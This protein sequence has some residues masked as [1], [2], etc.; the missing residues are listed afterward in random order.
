MMDH[1]NELLA[2]LPEDAD[3]SQEGENGN[4]EG[5]VDSEASSG[6]ED[7]DTQWFHHDVGSHMNSNKQAWLIGREI[8]ILLSNATD[9]QWESEKRHCTLLAWFVR[10]SLLQKTVFPPKCTACSCHVG[11]QPSGHLVEFRVVCFVLL[12][13]SQNWLPHLNRKQGISL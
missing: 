11:R 1:V 10:H 3:D 12:S 7:M 6:E 13:G 2:S 4:M 9:N 8:M 5:G